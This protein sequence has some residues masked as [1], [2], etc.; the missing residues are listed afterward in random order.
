MALNPSIAV[1]LRVLDYLLD[2]IEV[3]EYL[4]LLWGLHPLG[5][6]GSDCRELRYGFLDLLELLPWLFLSGEDGQLNFLDPVHA[7]LDERVLKLSQTVL[8]V[9]GGAG[10]QLYQQAARF[11]VDFVIHCVNGNL[12][13]AVY[14]LEVP[15]SDLDV[16]A[17]VL[18]VTRGAAVILVCK[19]VILVR[20]SRVARERGHFRG[21]WVLSYDSL[22]V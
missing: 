15:G 7:D 4:P 3:L 14:P 10:V 21:C 12:P 8:K 20:P 6:G 19:R 13:D 16:K 11:A 18:I 2:Q 22:S 17:V 9:E 1:L 5:N